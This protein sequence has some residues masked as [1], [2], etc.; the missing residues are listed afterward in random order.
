MSERLDPEIERADQRMLGRALRRLRDEAGMTQEQ[1]AEELG[2]DAKLVSRIERGTRG[3]RWP[4]LM[5]FL[6]VYKTDVHAL[7]RA[8]DE[9]AED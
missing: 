2:A 6:R 9:A 5:R 8:L 4:T 1:T 3:V 7:A